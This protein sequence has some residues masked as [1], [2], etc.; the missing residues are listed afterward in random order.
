M[1]FLEEFTMAMMLKIGIVVLM[2]L[3][4]AGVIEANLFRRP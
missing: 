3:F 1:D 2:G 4:A